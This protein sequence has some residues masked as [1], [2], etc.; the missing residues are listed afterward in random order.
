MYMSHGVGQ[1]R[2]KY[3]VK[4]PAMYAPEGDASGKPFNCVQRGAHGRQRC[5]PSVVTLRLQI[6]LCRSA[7]AACSLEAQSASMSRLCTC[8]GVSRCE[9][10]TLL[11]EGEAHVEQ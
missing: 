9:A 5:L 11:S 2:K 1:A 10:S 6:G 7:G 3:G 4:Y 8:S